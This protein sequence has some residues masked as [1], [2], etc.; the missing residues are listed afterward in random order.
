MVSTDITLSDFQ[1]HELGRKADKFSVL[2][3]VVERATEKLAAAEESVRGGSSTN[4]SKKRTT[5]TRTPAPAESL[6]NMIRQ[7]PLRRGIAPPPPPKLVIQKPLFAFD[8][9]RLSIPI[10]QIDEESD[11][12]GSST[13]PAKRRN[14]PTRTPS[15]AEGLTNKIR[16]LSRRLGIAPPPPPKLVIEKPMFAIDLSS[17]HNRLSIPIAQNDEES[18]RGGSST[19]PSKRKRTLTRTPAPAERLTNMIRQIPLRRGIAPPP[20]KLVIQKPLF[21]IDLSSQHNRLSIPIAQIDEESVRGG[22]STNPSKRKRTLTRTP[23]P[24][25]RLTNMIRQIPL[26]R[27]IAPPPPKLVIQKP[28][29]AIDL[30]SQ[31]NRLSIPIAQIDEESVRGGSST[32]PSKRKRTL[33]RTP[34][35]AERLTNMIRQIPLRRGI[36]PPPPKLVIQKPLFAIDLSSQ[37]N[38]LSIPIAQIAEESVQGGSSTNPAKRGNTLTRTPTPA[39]RLTNMIRQLSRRFGIAPPP[40]PKPV[41][42]KPLFATDL[43][44]QHNRLSI[45]ISQI[46]DDFLTEAE[47]HRLRGENRRTNYLDVK[48][49]AVAEA[50]ALSM[51]TA[52][53]CRWDMRKGIGRKTSSTY[54]INS[55]WHAFAKKNN[56]TVG[57]VVQ[58]WCFRLREELCFAIVPLPDSSAAA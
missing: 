25:E 26:R 34:A 38:R 49:T 42:E 33:T 29:F 44:P 39:E 32:N 55:K 7:I 4:P 11:H 8:L 22:S 17:Q 47:K 9:N 43:S 18:V 30:S 54:I 37:H 27:G 10:A 48:I 35:P 13:N 3:A 50:E 56:L 28:L 41:I 15:P 24:A 36:A 45:P 58:L 40:P 1:P 53:L 20:P 46:A 21:A 6:T 51:E 16:Q 23:A 31:H 14:T 19:N 12:G 57:L 52:K 2:L 5:L